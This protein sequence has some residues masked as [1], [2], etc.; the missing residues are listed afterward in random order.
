[1]AARLHRPQ[2]AEA[3]PLP[4]PHVGL[5][6]TDHRST[7]AYSPAPRWL[8]ENGLVFVVLDAVTTMD[9]DLLRRQRFMQQAPLCKLGFAPRAQDAPVVESVLEGYFD[10][11]ICRIRRYRVR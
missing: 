8:P 9:L 7:S 4:Q 10:H 11:G 6:R 2:P 3:A 5:R 1:M